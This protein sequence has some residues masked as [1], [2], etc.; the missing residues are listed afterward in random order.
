MKKQQGTEENLLDLKPVRNI[1]W[2]DADGEK[3]ILLV[4]KFHNKF[5]V[6]WIVPNLAKPN[7]RVSLDE[8]GSFVWQRC[9]GSATVGEIADALKVK[10]GETAEP[11]YDRTARFVQQ[12]LR[13]KF[14]LLPQ[15]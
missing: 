10:Y 9:D 5:F 8:Y 6:K 3:V 11:R 1:G 15:S 13:E 14:L 7:F 12:F 4:P 2:E